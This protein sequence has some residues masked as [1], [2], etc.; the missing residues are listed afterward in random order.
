MLMMLEFENFQSSRSLWRQYS[1]GQQLGNFKF[2][3]SFHIIFLF[4]ILFIAAPIVK[5]AKCARFTDFFYERSAEDES[6]RIVVHLYIKHAHSHTSFFFFFFP[7]FKLHAFFQ[8]FFILPF[9]TF[10]LEKFFNNNKQF[11]FFLA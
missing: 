7:K 11:I 8:I 5:F 2:I 4:F 1:F 10:I 9:T 3:L 6:T